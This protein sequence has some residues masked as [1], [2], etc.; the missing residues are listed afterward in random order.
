VSLPRLF[1]LGTLSLHVLIPYISREYIASY[2]AG[3]L[4]ARLSSSQAKKL[5]V[6]VSLSRSKWIL[7][8]HSN[9][10]SSIVG[11]NSVILKGNSGQS[12]GAITFSSE[13]RVINHDGRPPN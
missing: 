4:A 6:K 3:V 10:S 7:D 11:T 8:Q 1:F 5:N 13:A 12:S 2:P 9:I